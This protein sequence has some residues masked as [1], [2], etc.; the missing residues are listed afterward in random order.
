MFDASRLGM[1][2]GALF[3]ST[4]PTLAQELP[5]GKGKEAVAATCNNCH[6]RV[7]S[8]YTAERLAYGD[9]YIVGP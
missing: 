2:I 4:L 9:A 6:A 7:G 3:A 1:L 5:E 8:G